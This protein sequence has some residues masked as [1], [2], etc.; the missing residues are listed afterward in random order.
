MRHEELCHFGGHHHTD[1]TQIARPSAP[2]SMSERVVVRWRI[3]PSRWAA[4]AAKAG[5]RVAPERSLMPL[6]A[7]AEA[8]AVDQT[9]NQGRKVHRRDVLL[10]RTHHFGGG[11]GHKGS[12]T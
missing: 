6:A 3:S 7:R 1:E 10:L 11:R 9:A 8:P 2:P 5:L 12:I 4:A